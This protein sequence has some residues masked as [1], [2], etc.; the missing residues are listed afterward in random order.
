MSKDLLDGCFD[1]RD[2]GG[3]EHRSQPAGA[4]C[5]LGEG[6]R[7]VAVRDVELDLVHEVAL[8][9]EGFRSSMKRLAS[10]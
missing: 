9:A 7:L 2:A 4:C 1:W 10:E 8:I 6:P 3:V 5:L